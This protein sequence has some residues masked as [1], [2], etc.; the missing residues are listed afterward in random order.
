MRLR[1]SV[2][3]GGTFTDVVLLDEQGRMTIGKALTT[4]NRIFDGMAGALAVVAEER[5]QSV[6]D[7]LAGTDILIYGTTRAMNAV[8][9]KQTAKT[10]FV[11]TRGFRDTLTLKEGGKHGPNDYSYDYPDPYIPAATAS[12]STSASAPRVKLSNRSI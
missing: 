11:T 8:V 7:L 3:T 1:I 6:R 10:A 5:G 9:T 4:P 12:R 2:D